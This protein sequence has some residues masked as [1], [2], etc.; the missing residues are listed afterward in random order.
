M[1]HGAVHCAECGGGNLYVN[2]WIKV[3]CESTRP[4]EL[5]GNTDDTYCMDCDD[6]VHVAE[7]VRDAH[8]ALTGRK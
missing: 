4:D 7:F 5:D 6:V 3:N 8:D 2:R 1:E